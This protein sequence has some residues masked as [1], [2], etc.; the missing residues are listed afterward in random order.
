M[1]DSALPYLHALRLIPGIGSQTLRAL[2]EHFG[3]G[4]TAWQGNAAALSSCPHLKPKTVELLISGKKEIDPEK[5][6]GKLETEE[7][8]VLCQSDKH[9]PPLLKEIPDAPYLL[10][11]RG[12]FNWSRAHLRPTIAIVGS[13]KYTPYGEQAALRLSEEL[14]RAGFL[15]V[16]GL[17]FGIDSMAHKAALEAG[18]ETLAVL[19]SGI[20]DTDISPRSHVPLAEKIM[21]RGALVSEYPPGHPILPGNFPARNRIIAGLSLG[22]LVIEAAVGSGSLITADLALQYNREVFALPGSVFSPSSLG[23][24]QLIKKGAKMVTSVQDILE[25]LPEAISDKNERSPLKTTT[26]S[27]LAKE[28]EIVLKLLSH[29]PLHVDKITR[30]A[31]LETA[32]VTGLLSLLEIKGRIKNVGGMHYIKL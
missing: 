2:V 4:K 8:R 1:N 16:S 31:T 23:T 15:V 28:E 21:E 26:S 30:G 5:E 24:N 25:E 9:Y 20:S 19:G 27:G 29:E 12:N 14:T 18:G 17:A 32:H 22:T 13:R 11:V 6:W 10:Y 3:D 7:I